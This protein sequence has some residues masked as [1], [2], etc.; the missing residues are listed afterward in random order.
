MW[1]YPRPPR[2]EDTDEHLQVIVAG[3]VV[4]DTTRGK[5][6]LETSQPPTYYLPP[7]DVR[8]DLLEPATGT[9]YCE[10]KG[11]ATYH[12]IVVGGDRR[13]RA[14]WSYARPT[15][16]FAELAGWF[17]FYPRLVDECRVDGE[18]VEANDGSFYGGWITSKVVGP[19]K[20][21]PG[22]LHW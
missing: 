11:Q 22:T 8:L 7:D 17:A 18:R 15:P 3:T 1:D 12:S 5:R 2:V 6:V 13:D 9:S 21:A 10:W 4:A 20:G 16:A 19:F 14:V